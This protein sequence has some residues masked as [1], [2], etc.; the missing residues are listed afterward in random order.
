[1]KI[2][3]TVDCLKIKDWESFHDVFARSFGF[4]AFYGRNLN[5]W[6]DCMTCLDDE[7]MCDVKVL[8]GE[9]VLLQ[10]DNAGEL[11]PTAPDILNTIL[12]MSGFVN[13]RRVEIG[14]APILL[15]SCYA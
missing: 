7:G 6:I 1:M 4:P 2:T 13:W 12:E 10:L 9:Y 3:V 14:H 5:A 8:E 11:K 15:V